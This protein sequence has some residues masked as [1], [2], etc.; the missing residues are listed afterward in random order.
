[1]RDAREHTGRE[2][3]AGIVEGAQDAAVFERRFI[4]ERPTGWRRQCDP[5]FHIGTVASGGSSQNRS[6]F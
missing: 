5:A 4:G 1:M 3:V 2:R 6:S